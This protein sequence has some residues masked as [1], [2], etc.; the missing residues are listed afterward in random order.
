MA[1]NVYEILKS[2][3]PKLVEEVLDKNDSIS[4]FLMLVY[5]HLLNISVEKPQDPKDMYFEVQIRE[6]Q[7]N[8]CPLLIVKV[9]YKPSTD[10]SVSM[11]MDKIP[12]KRNMNLVRLM[13]VNSHVRELAVKIVEILEAW[14]NEKPYRKAQGMHNIRCEESMLY[15]NLVFATEII[16]KVQ[17]DEMV[18]AKMNW[19]DE[20]ELF[21]ERRIILV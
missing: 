12:F 18:K 2:E 17:Y 11:S 14:L 8:P 4:T 19:P 7:T 21:D 5:S 20:P 9:L 1:E 6:K 15:R 3:H 16:L 10:D 13:T